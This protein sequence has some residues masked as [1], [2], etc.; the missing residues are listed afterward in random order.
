MQIKWRA[1]TES[2]ATDQPISVHDIVTP[3]IDI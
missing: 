3:Q 2:V 1:D